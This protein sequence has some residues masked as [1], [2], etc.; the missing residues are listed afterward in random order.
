MCGLAGV[1]RLDG[2]PAGEEERRVVARM[3]ETLAHRGPDARGLATIGPTCLG[4]VRLAILDLSP[5][6]HMPMADAQGRLHLIY[7]GEVYNFREIRTQLERAGSCFR[8]GTDTEVVLAA[9]AQEGLAALDQCTGMFAFAL[10]DAARCELLLVRDRYGVKPLYFARAGNRLL[11]ASELKALLPELPQRALDRGQLAA[12]WL[13]RNVDGPGSATL[14]EGVEAVLPGEAVRVRGSRLE[15]QRWYRVE[16]QVAEQRL[17][18]QAM[19]RP[20]AV[21]EEIGALLEDSV[22]LRLVADV[23]VGILLSGGLDSSLVTAFA[24]RHARELTCFHVSLP[25]HAPLDERRHAERLARKLGLPLVVFALTAENFRNALVEVAWLEDLPLTH[26]NSVAYWHIARTARQ[27][28]VIVLLSGEGADELFGGYGWSYRRHRLLARLQPLFRLLPARIKEAL[29]LLIYAMNGLPV[30]VH[31]F[32]ELLPAAVAV[33]DGGLRAA[34]Q[35]RCAEAYAFLADATERRIAATML[36]DLGDF[37]SPLLR[38]LDRTTMGASVECREPFLDQRLVHAAINLPLDYRVGR[39]ADKWVLK[40]IALR[41]LPPEL[42]WR[43]K[44]GFPLPLA[45]YVEPLARPESFRHGFLEQVAGLTP[46]AIRR[47]L[48]DVR[49]FAYGTF[50]IIA[51]EMWGSLHLLGQSRE[52]V[53]AR[54]ALAG[55]PSRQTAPRAAAIA[56]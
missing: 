53:Q 38:R 52:E 49:S 28:G 29:T 24:A 37:L 21:V 5:A 42:V 32:R 7:N 11:F 3:L 31:R 48:T 6:G 25:D 17:Q 46:A 41:H 19:E 56:G 22:R 26:P 14:I 15:R 30:T 16:D 34:W 27:H 13:Y 36:A 10:F 45:D 39:R 1:F 51:L 44:M 43:P 40:Q 50:G 18:R 47:L 9:L 12:W 55:M 35:E 33:L 23:P 54:F 20:E 8:S 2:Q 4:S